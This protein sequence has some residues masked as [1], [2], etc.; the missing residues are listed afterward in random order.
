MTIDRIALKIYGAFWRVFGSFP[1]RPVAFH[2]RALAEIA[3]PGIRIARGIVWKP[4]SPRWQFS[5]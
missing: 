1:P 3:T 2:M 5:P 4:G